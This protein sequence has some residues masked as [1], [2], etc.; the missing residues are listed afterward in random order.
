MI[1][2]DAETLYPAQTA[3]NLLAYDRGYF[4]AGH[5]ARFNLF[6]LAATAAVVVLV[7]LPWWAHVG[8]P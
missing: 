6:L 4:N 1:V 3:A 8:L 2:V 7:A 5:L